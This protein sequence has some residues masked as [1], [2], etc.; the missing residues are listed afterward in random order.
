M[1]K[2]TVLVGVIYSGIVCAASVGL[3]D[4]RAVLERMKKLDV[5]VD[6]WVPDGC[7]PEDFIKFSYL[8]DDEFK[9]KVDKGIVILEETKLDQNVE[10]S[11]AL[12]NSSQTVK[13]KIMRA[14]EF[15]N[16]IHLVLSDLLANAEYILEAKSP[17]DS[18]GI[19]LDEL[20]AIQEQ[21]R[22]I[23]VLSANNADLLQFM[24]GDG[25]DKLEVSLKEELQVIPQASKSLIIEIIDKYKSK[26]ERYPLDL[27]KNGK[28]KVYLGVATS[29]SADA[30]AKPTLVSAE[31]QADA[32]AKPTLEVS[33]P[34]ELV[35]VDAPAK[36]TLVSAEV[37]TESPSV[38][39]KMQLKLKSP[40]NG[41]PGTPPVDTARADRFRAAIGNVFGIVRKKT[42]IVRDRNS[43]DPKA[44]II[45]AD[46]YAL[47][48]DSV[49][50][51][52]DEV[53]SGSAD[54]FMKKGPEQFEAIKKLDKHLK[55]IQAS[56]KKKQKDR[57]QLNRQRLSLIKGDRGN[58]QQLTALD[59]EIESLNDKMNALKA[60]SDKVKKIFDDFKK[61]G[62]QSPSSIKIPQF[63]LVLDDQNSTTESA[64]PTEGQPAA[65][66]VRPTGD[67]RQPLATLPQNVAVV[68]QNEE[69]QTGKKK[70]KSK[71]EQLAEQQKGDERRFGLGLGK[72]HGEGARKKGSGNIPMTLREANP[73]ST[74]NPY[75]EDP[76]QNSG[77]LFI[78]P[79]HK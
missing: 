50:S 10:M 63:V 67:I 23:S 71:A 1:F 5:Q 19:S 35:S 66:V 62:V 56:I 16:H 6:R 69:K 2:L 8:F 25:L 43:L 42:S 14:Q 21:I 17:G 40:A 12:L 38:R 72:V 13:E 46:D 55:K 37:Q 20:R 75:P 68:A 39:P 49:T 65:R 27:L 74:D 36:P 70:G 53:S 73:V 29:V 15:R 51:A 32:P 33:S 54:D 77:I 48:K 30:P 78:T 11:L 18:D 45:T 44:I 58:P 9:R 61:Q 79:P 57:E 59:R 7:T 47:I 52:L 76:R 3:V 28:L 64:P 31:V 26:T 24:E 34:V 22:K 60:I 41:V 4:T